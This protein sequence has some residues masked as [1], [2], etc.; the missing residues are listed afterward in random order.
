MSAFQSKLSAIQRS[1][2]LV[3]ILYMLV[4]IVVTPSLVLALPK[5]GKRRGGGGS[6]GGDDDDEDNTWLYIKIAAIVV[7]VLVSCCVCIAKQ[8]KEQDNDDSAEQAAD[9]Q[10][11]QVPDKP[12][13]VVNMDANVV[14][15]EGQQQQQAYPPGTQQ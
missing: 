10:E 1:R 2:L 15:Q 6:F 7:G 8:N 13:A 3:A 14:G 11:Q 5:G 4:G 9:Q 12:G